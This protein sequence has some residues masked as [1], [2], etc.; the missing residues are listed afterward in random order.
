MIS[1]LFDRS[2]PGRR[3]YTKRWR[4]AARDARG[5]TVRRGILALGFSSKPREG[6]EPDCAGFPLWSGTADVLG[7]SR[8][9]TLPLRHRHSPSLT[10]FVLSSFLP[11]LFCGFDRT[12]DLYYFFFWSRYMHLDLVINF[13]KSAEHSWNIRWHFWYQF[14]LDSKL[15]FKYVCKNC[16]KINL[17]FNLDS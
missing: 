7:P 3:C 13:Y 15:L 16:V 4:G 5:T 1:V 6:R 10:L 2:G 17:L 9:V 11:R 14:F 12:L 8:L